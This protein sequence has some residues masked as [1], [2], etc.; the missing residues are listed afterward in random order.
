MENI[1]RREFITGILSLLLPAIPDGAEAAK[2]SGVRVKLPKFPFQ[3][4]VITG[5]KKGKR[6]L[7][8]G[9]IHGNEPGAYKA[10]DI[11]RNV[12]V[13]KGEL[14]I[15]PRSNF[16]SVLANVRGYNG[17]MN[18]KFA[19]ISPKDPDY[20]CVKKLK[21]LIKELKPD[22]VLSLHD[23]YGFHILNKR[24]W[25]Q[26]IVIDEEVYSGYPLGKIAK[27]VAKAIL[28]QYKEEI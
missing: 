22:V 5:K 2:G 17:D 6:I 8:V 24:F 18:R 4:T 25:G 16:L 3:S 23:G 26:C 20:P 27:E 1:R 28:V 19:K 21:E 13:E 11:L 7:I 12:E 10:A 15:A 9:G 14:I